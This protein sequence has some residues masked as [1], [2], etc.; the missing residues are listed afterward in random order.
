MWERIAYLGETDGGSAFSEALTADVEAVF[1]D[2]SSL[3]TADLAV[4]CVR[5]VARCDH[6]SAWVR[7][8]MQ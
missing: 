2:Q 7:G 3:V 8:F 4:K 6:E 5:L 1:P